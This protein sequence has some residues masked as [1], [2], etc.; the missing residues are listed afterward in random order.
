MFFNLEQ[1]ACRGIKFGLGTHQHVPYKVLK[2]VNPS[3]NGSRVICM[4]SWYADACNM[5]QLN[6]VIRQFCIQFLMITKGFKFR[7]CAKCLLMVPR[8]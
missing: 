1:K 4:A 2:F 3:S 8:C 6:R 7:N 5:G